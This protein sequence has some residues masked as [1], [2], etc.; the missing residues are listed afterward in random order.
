[1]AQ[2]VGRVTLSL[3]TIYKEPCEYWS[4]L[5]LRVSNRFP[6]KLRNQDLL[7]LRQVDIVLLE[8]EVE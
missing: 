5:I 1:M 2:G 3:N 8:Y 6:F 4:F 7:R